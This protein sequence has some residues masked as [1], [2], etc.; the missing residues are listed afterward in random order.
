MLS[1]LDLSYHVQGAITIAFSTARENIG[2]IDLPF[3]HAQWHTQ[4]CQ[5]G[6]R[7]RDIGQCII[8]RKQDLEVFEPR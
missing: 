6:K 8:S 2:Y 1:A 5:I 3:A 4:V 7:I